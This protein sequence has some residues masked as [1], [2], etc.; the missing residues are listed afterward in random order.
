MASLQVSRAFPKSSASWIV[1]APEAV[2]HNASCRQ[3]SEGE[4]VSTTLMRGFG[5]FMAG[6]HQNHA[7]SQMAVPAV[8]N[9]STGGVFLEDFLRLL[10]AQLT[11][12]DPLKPMDNTAFL[13]QMAQF[14]TLQQ[15]QVLN[16]QVS[17]LLLTDMSNQAIGLLGRTVSLVSN[18]QTVSGRVTGISFKDSQPVVSVLVGTQTIDGVALASISAIR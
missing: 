5:R 11:Q 3:R 6:I 9:T 15:T 4:N 12:Q 17:Q 13:A 7:E 8:S 10:L 16:Q 18:G 2:C 1:L 14:T